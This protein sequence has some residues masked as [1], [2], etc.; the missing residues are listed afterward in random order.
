VRGPYQDASRALELSL[1]AMEI[2]LHS[3]CWLVCICVS[4]SALLTLK[5]QCTFVEGDNML[6]SARWNSRLADI[7]S[8][9]NGR[10]R[11]KFVSLSVV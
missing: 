5:L 2:N 6:R 3:D 10:P 11:E 7:D 9:R 8:Q 1:R 4:C